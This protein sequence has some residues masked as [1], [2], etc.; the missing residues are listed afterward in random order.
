MWLQID[1]ISV[2][3][4]RPYLNV[5]FSIFIFFF[6]VCNKMSFLYICVLLFRCFTK[7]NKWQYIFCSNNIKTLNGT[8]KSLKTFILNNFHL[9]VNCNIHVQTVV[10]HMLRTSL[11]AVFFFNLERIFSFN[12][13]FNKGKQTC[14]KHLKWKR[15]RCKR[16]W[17]YLRD[18][19]LFNNAVWL[20]LKASAQEL[21]W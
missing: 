3:Q 13:K 1:K 10:V 4:R 14:L 2:K 8:S 6:F 21:W 19:L 18:W 16:P 5:R 15:L 17:G 11:K 12:S 9:L 7:R 20:T